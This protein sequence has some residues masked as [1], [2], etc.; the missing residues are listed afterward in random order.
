MHQPASLDV[1]DTVVIRRGPLHHQVH[2]GIM[3]AVSACGKGKRGRPTTGVCP[4]FSARLPRHATA[5]RSQAPGG[6]P[7]VVERADPHAFSLEP[8]SS[9]PG[10][11]QH[12]EER[13]RGVFPPRET[14]VFRG[15]NRSVSGVA[16]QRRRRRRT[17][18]IADRCRSPF[19]CLRSST[20]SPDLPRAAF[21]RCAGVPR[22]DGSTTPTRPIPVP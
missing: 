13:T 8:D 10:K 20:A 3:V 1:R 22:A 19:V 2:V 15:R 17:R 16:S 7:F 12:P 18:S 11:K 14:G 4:D 5:W 21:A 6:L 9:F